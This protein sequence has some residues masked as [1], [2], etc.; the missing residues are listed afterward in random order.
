MRAGQRDRRVTL[1][2]ATLSRGET[3]GKVE[4]WATVATVYARV[5]DANGSQIFQA[6]ATGNKVDVVVNIR[7]RAGVT[8]AMRV[9]LHDGRVARITWVKVIGR[10]RE[11]ELYCE[12]INE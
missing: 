8:A 5:Q 10:D 2:S 4:T 7:H 9:L 3:G 12:A 1:Q 11:L 6:Q